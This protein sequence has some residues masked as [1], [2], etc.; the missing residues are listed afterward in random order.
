MVETTM[1]EDS[2]REALNIC[3]VGELPEPLAKDEVRIWVKGLAK[4][5]KYDNSENWAVVK[6]DG[7]G[8]PHILNDV[9]GHMASIVKIMDVHPTMWLDQNM[10]PTLNKKSDAVRYLSNHDIEGASVKALLSEKGKTEEQIE[11]DK[12]EVMKM[13]IKCALADFEMKGDS[14][15]LDRETMKAY[16]EAKNGEEG[17]EE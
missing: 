12:A 9:G 17:T 1:E 10:L 6:N 7:S 16:E 11:E 14:E 15:R 8:K 13:I 3:M 5:R 2:L 4:V